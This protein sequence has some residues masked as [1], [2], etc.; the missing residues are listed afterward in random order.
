MH[1]IPTTSSSKE[2]V[3]RFVSEAQAMK[4]KWMVILNDGTDSTKNDYLVT[5]LVEKGIM[6]VMRIFT[7]NGEP[8]S[9]DLA[10]MVRHYKALGVD[11]FQLYNEP[12]NNGENPNGKPDVGQYL[13]KWIP[14]AKIVAAN[15][16]L[17]GF[18]ALS[19]GGNV[20]D[21]EFLRSALEEIK[22]RGEV[23]VLG[24]AW[25]AIHNYTFNRPIDYTAD[26]NGF[27]KFRWYDEIVREAIGR[28]LPIIGTEGGTQV[29]MQHDKNYPVVDEA[30]QAR[31][32]ADA[33][34]YM[35]NAEPYYFAY[36]NWVIANE[37]GGGMDPQFSDQAL[38]R[39][40]GATQAVELLKDLG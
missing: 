19:P 6:P 18:A 5:K 36:S 27:L 21:L 32:L 28:S 12:N 26:S 22:R 30:G 11:Y 9:G 16:G 31:T 29:G 25:V 23:S 8:I 39:P 1:W 13:D 38:F 34:R 24:K 17:P 4:V 40:D 15:G 14:A 33:Y 35:S 37:A 2:V 20:D 3:D 7:P 10:G